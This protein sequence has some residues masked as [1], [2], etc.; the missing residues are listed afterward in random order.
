MRD[1]NFNETAEEK[2]PFLLAVIKEKI[3]EFVLVV[4]VLGGFLYA[5]V[6]SPPCLEHIFTSIWAVPS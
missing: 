2:K 5:V 6:G 4:I 3:L 1:E